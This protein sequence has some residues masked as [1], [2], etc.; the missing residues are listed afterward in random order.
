MS[1]LEGVMQQVESGPQ[2]EPSEP[3]LIQQLRKNWHLVPPTQPDWR[4]MRIEL[5]RYCVSVPSARLKTLA[6]AA[7]GVGEKYRGHRLEVNRSIDP[8][9]VLRCSRSAISSIT[10]CPVLCDRSD[11]R[12]VGRAAPAPAP[13]ARCGSSRQG[14][15]KSAAAAAAADPG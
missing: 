10:H 4:V 8:N 7:L 15:T 12:G 13:A 1:C 14:R 9:T 3:E 2:E 5:G 11:A 6:E